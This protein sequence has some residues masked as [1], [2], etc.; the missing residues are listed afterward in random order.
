VVVVDKPQKRGSKYNNQ[1]L[2]IKVMEE[3]VD[4]SR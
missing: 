1:F 4:L 3:A 2:K